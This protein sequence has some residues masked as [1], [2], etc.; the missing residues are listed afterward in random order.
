ML[1]SHMGETAYLEN[2]RL[3]IFIYTVYLLLFR[4]NAE[5]TEIYCLFLLLQFFTCLICAVSKRH[6]S[7]IK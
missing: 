3:C 2:L 4:V 1:K 6:A 7:N 5:F